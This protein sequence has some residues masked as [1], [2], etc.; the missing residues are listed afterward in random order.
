MTA[1]LKNKYSTLN[2]MQTF[3][4]LLLS[5][6]Y[7]LNLANLL[8]L[9]HFL[10]LSHLSDLPDLP[11]LSHRTETCLSFL[12][13]LF[14]SEALLGI[15]LL[16][17]L[18]LLVTIMVLRRQH[19]ALSKGNSKLS[20]VRRLAR[21]DLLGMSG[22]ALFSEVDVPE[23][24]GQASSA[25]N[26]DANVSD[27]G[28]VLEHLLQILVRQFVWNVAD[29]ESLA[30]LALGLRFVCGVGKLHNHLAAFEDASVL[31]GDGVRGFL[32]GAECDVAETIG[33]R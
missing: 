33:D 17:Q 27:A 7:L 18:L 11:D 24:T 25:V 19:L 15:D 2:Y 26:G 10:D 1:I 21:E 13:S 6:S 9:L 30:G 3:L 29:V 32:N 5:L 28:N 14:S 8:N 16:V 31:L 20:T 23:P 4:L 22:I 12:S